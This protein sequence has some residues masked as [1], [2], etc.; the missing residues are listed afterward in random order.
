MIA[1]HGSNVDIE[2]VDLKM[3]RRYT[4]F[5]K[6]FYLSIDENQARKRA[7][8]KANAYG[9]SPVVTKWEILTEKCMFEDLNI[10]EFETETEEWAEF[11]FKSREIGEENEYDIVIGPIA[12]DNM[13]YLF[14]NVRL[15]QMTIKELVEKLTYQMPTKQVCFRTQRSLK[16]L[17]KI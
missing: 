1:F 10:K 8:A 17:K 5:G 15:K 14:R 13:R 2:S 4:D 12:D 7:E 6:G 16:I 11:V 9:G 3:C